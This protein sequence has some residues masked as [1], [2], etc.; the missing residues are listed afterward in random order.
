[1]SK[2]LLALNVGSSS[3]K[4]ALFGLTSDLPVHLQG[5]VKNIGTQPT[6]ILSGKE[7]RTLEPST[8]QEEAIGLILKEIGP[9]DQLSAAVHRV[10]HGG[11]IYSEPTLIDQ[12]V[13]ETLKNF[14]SLAP[15]HQPHN[16]AGIEILAKLLPNLPQIATFDTAFHMGRC[17]LTTTYALPASLRHEGIQRYGFHGLSY[18]WTARTLAQERPEIAQ[19]RIVAAHLG[20]GVSVCALHK[21]KS[22]DTSMGMTTLEGPPMG[23]RSGNLDPGALL[24]MID[25]LG[26]STREITKCLYQESGL[27]GL[28]GISGD[29]KALLESNDPNA[30]F[31]LEHFAFRVSQ[32]MAMM[33]VSLGGVDAFVFTGGIG[34]KAPTIRSNILHH[35]A[36][37]GHIPSHVIVANE[38]LM[39]A[40]HAYA[41][42]KKNK[43]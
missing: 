32:Y 12:G 16:L 7:K 38:E 20:S 11:K 21:G 37:L 30:F 1:M 2:L 17:A 18:E 8:T 3:V 19:S 43:S 9:I 22:V 42:L 28:S 13:L 40:M 39:M 34:E 31:A 41:C 6:L 26:M 25:S 27:K 36:F 33:V 14:I 35:L 4:F 5:S 10:V 15:L 29:V 24:Y 23:T